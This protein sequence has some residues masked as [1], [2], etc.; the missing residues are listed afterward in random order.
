MSVD[1]QKIVVDEKGCNM[2]DTSLTKQEVGTVENHFDQAAERAYGTASI[3]SNI[4]AKPSTDL[5]H[6]SQ[7]RLLPPAFPFHHVLL[8]RRRPL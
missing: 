1:N 4:V 2:S 6:S 8:Q 7:T 5:L 3:S